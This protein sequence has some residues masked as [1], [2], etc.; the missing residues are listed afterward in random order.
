MYYTVFGLCSCELHDALGVFHLKAPAPLIL[1]IPADVYWPPVLGTGIAEKYV[2][3][4]RAGA[5]VS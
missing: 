1:I 5:C 4:A 2:V 3:L